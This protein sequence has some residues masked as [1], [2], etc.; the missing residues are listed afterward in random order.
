MPATASRQVQPRATCRGCGRTSSPGP[1]PRERWPGAAPR[2]TSA[3][4][5][6]PP[7]EPRES[8]PPWG[9][10]TPARPRSPATPRHAGRRPPDRCA[11]GC[12]RRHP[13]PSAVT[14]QQSSIPTNG[15]PWSRTKPSNRCGAASTASCPAL[16]SPLASATNGCPSPLVASLRSRRFTGR[17]AHRGSGPSVPST[18]AATPSASPWTLRPVRHGACGRRSSR[19]RPPPTRPH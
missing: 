19:Q 8:A 9:S 5:L 1:S 18:R 6:C 17:L 11:P 4:S 12:P 2:A 16:A 13:A 10:A 3:I 7:R 14:D 15:P